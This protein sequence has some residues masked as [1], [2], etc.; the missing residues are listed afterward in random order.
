MVCRIMTVHGLSGDMLFLVHYKGK[1]VMKNEMYLI[2]DYLSIFI[3]AIT[4]TRRCMTHYFCL[5]KK[6]EILARI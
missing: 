1:L 5:N 4:T 3:I 2:S 6:L